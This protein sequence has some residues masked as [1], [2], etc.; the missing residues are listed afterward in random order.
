ME[1]NKPKKVEIETYATDM[2]GALEDGGQGAIRKI[3]EQETAYEEAKKKAAGSSL[4]NQL[5]LL[6]S[7]LL[8]LATIGI[9]YYVV[10]RNV[11]GE[12]AITPQFTPVIFNDET[13]FIEAGEEKKDIVGQVDWEAKISEVPEGGVKGIYLMEQG[14]L[15]GLSR[16]ASLLETSV[17][18]DNSI[19]SDNFLLGTV[20]NDQPELFLLVKVYSFTDAFNFMRDWEK[21]MFYDLRELF[22]VEL[23]SSNNYLLTKDFEDGIVGNKNARILRD[24]LGNIALMYVFADDNFIVIS[25]SEDAVGEVVARLAGGSVKK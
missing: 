6:S 4:W 18:I 16:L 9:I 2:A 13:S 24:N 20:K 11:G 1:E 12:V 21:K 5:Y 25:K 14:Q 22:D 10:S 19:F 15:L 7:V 3:I 23:T 17:T 8:V